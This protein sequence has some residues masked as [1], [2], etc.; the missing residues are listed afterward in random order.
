VSPRTLIE[1]LLGLAVLG[2]A[3]RFR[4]RGPYWRWRMHTAFPEGRPTV[5]GNPEPGWTAQRLELARL[6]LEYGAWA[7]RTG[8]LR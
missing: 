4:L 6:A 7:F 1:G 5:P 2:V 8:R 3:T